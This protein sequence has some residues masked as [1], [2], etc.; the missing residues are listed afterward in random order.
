MCRAAGSGCGRAEQGAGARGKRREQGGVGRVATTL[1]GVFVVC[2]WGGRLGA[3][4]V[5]N[6]FV[7]VTCVASASLC[8]YLC[9]CR[10]LCD[11][12]RRLRVLGIGIGIGIG[13]GNGNG[14]AIGTIGVAPGT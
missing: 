7:V 3:A 11:W 10:A 4:V 1:R 6:A 8:A 9:F 5:F 12:R 13:I 14:I 2:V